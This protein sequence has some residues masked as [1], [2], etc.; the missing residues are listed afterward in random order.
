MAENPTSKFNKETT[1][2]VFDHN[3]REY[4]VSELSSALKIIVEKTKANI[5]FM[6]SNNIELI[7][8]F[9]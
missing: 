2:P 1:E 3:L 6:S 8:Y 5:A 9:G 4:S 7:D